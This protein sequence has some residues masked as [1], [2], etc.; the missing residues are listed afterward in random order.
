VV[1]EFDDEETGTRHLL[2]AYAGLQRAMDG[3]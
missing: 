1:V 2:A 3:I